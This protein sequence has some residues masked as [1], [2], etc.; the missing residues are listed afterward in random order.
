MI[1]FSG[2]ANLEAAEAYDFAGCK[3][4]VDVGGGHGQLLSAIVARNPHLS[5]VLYDLPAGIDAA[6][7]GVGGPLPRCDL[8]A[9]DFFTS[10]PEGCDAYIMKKV[11]HD[12]DD[13]RAAMILDNCRRAM[14]P[15]GKVL[16][17]ETIVPAGN[18]PDP[19]KVMDVN[20]LAV[21][22]GLERTRDQYERLFARAGLRLARVIAT[23]GPLSILEAVAG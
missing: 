14:A 7:A 13:G 18:D 11:I 15:G 16:V 3:R 9:G 19:I 12:W 10:V 17:V 5:G 22:G 8:M 4:V 6:R 1:A 21:T 20:M 2:P 23:R